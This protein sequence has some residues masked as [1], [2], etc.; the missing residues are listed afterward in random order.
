MTLSIGLRREVSR[1]KC[2]ASSGSWPFPRGR[3]GFQ[4]TRHARSGR[5]LGA[6]QKYCSLWSFDSKM[7][8]PS[9]MNSQNKMSVNVQLSRHPTGDR[10]AAHCAPW[11]GPYQWYPVPSPLPSASRGRAYTYCGGYTHAS[12]HT[13]LCAK[14]KAK[15]LVCRLK[16]C[17]WM[18][19]RGAH[20]IVSACLP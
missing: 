6:E 2:P 14:P 12:W 15:R 1:A 9:L 10:H 8:I 20:L 4:C 3:G 19:A 18:R 17:T 11:G 13:L 7:S 16:H 5:P